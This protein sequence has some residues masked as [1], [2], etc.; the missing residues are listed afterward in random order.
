MA[1]QKK[2]KVEKP[3]KR[4]SCLLCRIR[5]LKC[6]S[7][8]SHLYLNN[9]EINPCGN[10]L[11]YKAKCE[12][13]GGLN[14]RSLIKYLSRDEY[15]ELLK[16]RE[17]LAKTEGD[18]ANK[19]SPTPHI[20][21]S[22]DK[23]YISKLSPFNQTD[24]AKNAIHEIRSYGTQNEIKLNLSKYVTD[25]AAVMTEEEITKERKTLIL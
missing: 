13:F 8:S 5:K 18:E 7:D 17:K 3:L 16:E 10:C 14:D 15:T 23:S 12:P 11:I 20:S 22:V 9:G 19:A 24:E 4:K 6:V 25:S 1:R 21:N 2:P